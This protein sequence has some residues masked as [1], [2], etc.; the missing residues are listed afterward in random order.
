MMT[1]RASRSDYTLQYIF[2]CKISIRCPK[3]SRYFNPSKPEKGL[4]NSQ[5]D[6]NINFISKSTS[7]VS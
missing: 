3:F 2:F 4:L 1:C 5:A 6:E 7:R